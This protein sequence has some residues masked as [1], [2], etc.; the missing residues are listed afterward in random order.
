MNPAL[1]DRYL[2]DYY[3]LRWKLHKVQ[4]T[5][6]DPQLWVKDCKTSKMTAENQMF[7]LK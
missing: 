7:N 6:A 2:T 3:R 1:N 4:R 5:N